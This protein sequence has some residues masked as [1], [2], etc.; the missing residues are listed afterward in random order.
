MKEKAQ[1]SWLDMMKMHNMKLAIRIV[2]ARTVKN[3]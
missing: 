3:V 2:T 1:E